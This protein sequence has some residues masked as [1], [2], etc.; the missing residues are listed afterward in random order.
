M[1]VFLVV[2]RSTRLS[3]FF[4]FLMI[5]R[6]PRS[7]LFPYTTLFRSIDWR[8]TGAVQKCL[9]ETN[10]DRGL[11]GE[12]AGEIA[13]LGRER[14]VLHRLRREPHR[15]CL[16]GR[17]P[18]AKKN[19]F[20]RLRLTEHTDEPLRPT[21][22][23]DE[24]Q[25]HFGQTELRSLRRNAEVARQGEFETATEAVPVDR[26]ERGLREIRKSIQDL[27]AAAGELPHLERLGN[28]AEGREVG[29]RTEGAVPRARDDETP[30][31]LVLLQFSQGLLELVEDLRA[32]RVQSIGSVERDRRDMGLGI[33][34]HQE[35]FKIHP[36]ASF[37]VFVE[38]PPGL[39]AE[40]SARS[41]LLEDFCRLGDLTSLQIGQ[42][43]INA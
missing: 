31:G 29:S 38:S 8:V 15:S 25:T 30:D 13:D 36:T 6:P 37:L 27:L 3:F 4:F 34:R 33:F 43:D 14:L 1:Y 19:E 23:W 42:D 10:R 20:F 26:R 2:G 39:R 22:P 24:A 12:S 28:V 16:V 17:E 18:S 21:C 11:P 5:R 35:S 41:H 40:V 32:H 9:R 7:T